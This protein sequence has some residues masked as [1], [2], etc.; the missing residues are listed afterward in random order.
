MIKFECKAQ[1]VMQ[2]SYCN[3]TLVYIKGYN[4]AYW[5]TAPCL[6]DT[7]EVSSELQQTI[8]AFEINYNTF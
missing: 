3:I 5:Q 7:Y 6:C 4:L 8:M 2:Y 1:E